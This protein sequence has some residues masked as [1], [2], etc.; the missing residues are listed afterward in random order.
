MAQELTITQ[1]L[2]E[3]GH[4]YERSGQNLSRLKRAF[5]QPSES[6][7]HATKMVTDDTIFKLANNVFNPVLQA[8]Q[9]AFTPK[10][11]VEFI[12]NP[13]ILRP[14]KIDYKF[15]PTDVES[16]WLGFLGG[17][18]S[19]TLESWPVVKYMLE[20]YL[21]NQAIEDKELNEVYKGIWVEPE[22]GVAGLSGKSMDGF[23][24][25]LYDGASH[26]SYPINVVEGVGELEE[27]S[28]F[29][30]LEYYDK[31]IS[32]LYIG[33]RLI[34]FVAQKWVRAFKTAKRS[35]GY[36]FID[37]ADKINAAI[38]FTQHIVIGLPSMNGT[39]DIFTTMSEN[40][41][42]LRKRDLNKVHVDLQ[43]IDRE[44][45][46]LIHW[47]EAVG[48]GCNKLVWTTD[49]TIRSISSIFDQ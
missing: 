21:I 41:L 29:D 31:Q 34:H 13:I 3:Y 10:G 1:I 7:Q 26:G 20:E 40:M 42:H 33:K 35:N 48:F 15:F 24:K 36:Y 37:S 11:G 19:R 28:I 2:D 18:S 49:A 46:F 16:S 32:E 39:N 23:R 27:D 8:F 25:Q 45:K 47:W 44:I 12:P 43:K 6:L 4:Y 14:L 38:D 30:Q 5:M 22:E 9:K 17:D